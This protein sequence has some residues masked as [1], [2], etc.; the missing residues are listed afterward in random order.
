MAPTSPPISPK[1][2]NATLRLLA[3]QCWGPIVPERLHDTLNDLEVPLADGRSAR[4]RYRRYLMAGLTPNTDS[5]GGEGM[6][7]LRAGLP[8]N[9]AVQRKGGQWVITCE[10]TGPTMMM[11]MATRVEIGNKELLFACNGK[12]D[13]SEIRRTIFAAQVAGMITPTQQGAQLFADS[14]GGIDCSGFAGLCY[15]RGGSTNLEISSTAYRTRGIERKTVGEIRAG[16][17]IVWL[18][19]NHIAVISSVTGPFLATPALRCVVAESTAGNLTPP[20]PGLQC[21]EYL[22]DSDLTL[23]RP[24]ANGGYA[25]LKPSSFTVRGSP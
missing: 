13:L 18:Q 1:V 10:V 11:S 23:Y 19:T 7:K 8:A 16:D 25:T 20:G 12:G 22:F 17:A 21:S 3:P 5:S 15:G 6:N 2:T 14:W 9:P 4:I 24:R